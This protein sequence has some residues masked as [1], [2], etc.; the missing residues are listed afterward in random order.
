MVDHMV[1][2][3]KPRGRVEIQVGVGQDEA[4]QALPAQ[5]GVT[6]GL[7]KFALLAEASQLSAD[8]Q[9]RTSSER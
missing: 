9:I 3:S 2:T 5:Q 7:G 1:D 4:R 8:S 6:D